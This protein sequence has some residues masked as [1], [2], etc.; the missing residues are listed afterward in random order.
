MKKINVVNRFF[1]AVFD[2]LIIVSFTIL[3]CLPAIIT[4][5]DLSIASSTIDYVALAIASF[6]GGAITLCVAFCYLIAIP[7]FWNGQT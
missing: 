7:Y 5:V 2:F 6:S 1:A 3:I 4:F